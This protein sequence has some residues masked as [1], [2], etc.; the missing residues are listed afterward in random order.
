MTFIMESNNGYYLQTNDWTVGDYYRT[1][2]YA[3]LMVKD[4]GSCVSVN[5]KSKATIFPT[6]KEAI[7]KRKNLLTNFIVYPNS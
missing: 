5:E 2:E 4:D 3:Y 7:E 6:K 1:G